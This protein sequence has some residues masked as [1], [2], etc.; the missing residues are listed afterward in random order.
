[1]RK[2]VEGKIFARAWAE[3]WVEMMTPREEEVSSDELFARMGVLPT[4]VER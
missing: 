1:L 3:T 4:Y 2:Q